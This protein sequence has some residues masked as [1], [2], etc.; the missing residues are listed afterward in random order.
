[1]RHVKRVE[2]SSPESQW[3]LV[4]N[5]VNIQIMRGRIHRKYQKILSIRDTH[6][7]YRSSYVIIIII[8]SGGTF[9]ETTNTRSA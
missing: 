6:C 1:M 4:K 3:K 8:I 5:R 9:M 7:D 2:N